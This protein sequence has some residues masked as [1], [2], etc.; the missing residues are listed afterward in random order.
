MRI[1]IIALF[2]LLC[3][4][5]NKEDSETKSE[6]KKSDSDVS[7]KILTD[8]LF[9]GP[10]QNATA[11]NPTIARDKW[12]AIDTPKNNDF[13]VSDEA[14][15]ALL[16]LYGGLKWEDKRLIEYCEY[17]TGYITPAFESRFTEGG[18]EKLL[19]IGII[20]P[21]EGS[22]SACHACVPLIGGAIFVKQGAKWVVESEDKI[23]GWGGP[24][25][26]TGDIRIVRIGNDKFG[27]LIKVND[28]HQGYEDIRYRILVPKNGRLI[29]ALDIGFSE[30]P[31]EGACEDVTNL[32]QSIDLNFE[33]TD[34]SEYFDITARFQ[35]ND[36]DCKH[37]VRKDETLRY[38]L[39]DGEYK[40]IGD[41]D[42]G[43]NN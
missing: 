30:Q 9:S 13:N 34:D 16:A 42:L 24:Y 4:C 23:I 40:Q 26:T 35:F 25:G 36:G 8:T 21:E 29:L 7:S 33:P 22:I 32:L 20:A 12:S 37:I 41:G 14:K 3:A 2:L 1:L 6:E 38:R 19:A 27:V 28:M 5:S 15:E 39:K 18:T 17:Q 43:K 31:S 10:G 11:S